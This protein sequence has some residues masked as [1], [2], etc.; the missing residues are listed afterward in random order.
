MAKVYTEIPEGQWLTQVGRLPFK[1]LTIEKQSKLRKVLRES[2]GPEILLVEIA[3]GLVLFAK[4]EN[5]QT[6]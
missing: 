1:G 3:S 2:Y 4:P 5:V 6:M